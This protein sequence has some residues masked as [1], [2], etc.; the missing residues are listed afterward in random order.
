MAMCL[1]FLQFV[2]C[3][4]FGVLSAWGAVVAGSESENVFAAGS[5]ARQGQV[6]RLVFKLGFEK[7][8]ADALA[9]K[10]ATLAYIGVGDLD[11]ARYQYD[12][13]MPMRGG[14]NV[15][16]LRLQT[17]EKLMAAYSR[18]GSFYSFV[19]ARN[20]FERMWRF[21]AL[22]GYLDVER[23]GVSLGAL[24]VRHY[25]LAHVQSYYDALL[26]DGDPFYERSFTRFLGAYLASAYLFRGDC[27][28]A[29]AVYAPLYK[30]GISNSHLNAP[31]T[32]AMVLGYLDLGNLERAYA[33]FE[34]G[35]DGADSDLAMVYFAE[36]GVLLALVSA[37]IRVNHMEDAYAIYRDANAFEFSD[38]AMH[39]CALMAQK[40]VVAYIEQGELETA[41]SVAAS[42]AGQGENAEVRRIRDDVA[43]RVAEAGLTDC[44]CD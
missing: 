23:M 10:R 9:A 39:S 6:L 29:D 3:G 15:L 22:H 27:A 17:T 33:F 34:K 26:G 24:Y 36:N 25:P 13:M 28:A 4:M 35:M 38:L 21:E 40:L 12:A 14:R 16:V 30:G 5:E 8:A 31:V 43:A 44:D 11:A 41:S 20:L 2:I 7:D 19:K 18:E 1:R 32:G 37:L 42:M